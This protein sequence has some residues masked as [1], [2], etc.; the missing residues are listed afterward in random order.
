[1]K[2]IQCEKCGSVELTKTGNTFICQACGT[3]YDANDSDLKKVSIDHSEDIQRLFKAA[4]RAKDLGNY[5]GAQ[6]YYDEILG[7]NPDSWEAVFNTIYLRFMRGKIGEIDLHAT[8][9]IQAMPTII[10]LIHDEYSPEEQDAALTEVEENIEELNILFESGSEY[11]QKV[12][13]DGANLIMST[14]SITG[15]LSGAVERLDASSEFASSRS[16]SAKMLVAF[17]D[18]V[19]ETF[20]AEIEADGRDAIKETMLRALKGAAAIYDSIGDR[21]AESKVADSIRKWEPEYETSNEKRAREIEESAREKQKAAAQKKLERSEAV[22]KNKKSIIGGIIAV[23]ILVVAALAVYFLVVAPEAQRSKAYE[24][25]LTMT[26]YDAAARQLESLGDYKDSSE[27]AAEFGKLAEAESLFHSGH[28]YEALDILAE[29]PESDSR[30]SNIRTSCEYFIPE[31]IFDAENFVYLADS[32]RIAFLKEFGEVKSSG[33]DG[34][35]DYILHSSELLKKLPDSLRT[36]LTSDN[37]TIRVYDKDVIEEYGAEYST[38]SS[39]KFREYVQYQFDSGWMNDNLVSATK[40]LN[41]AA[42]FEVYSDSY[43]QCKSDERKGW[44]LGASS[45]YSEVAVDKSTGVAQILLQ[46]L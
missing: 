35:T 1:M 26:D 32:D 11:L 25:A 16:L 14:G 19:D 2:V 20:G 38:F 34:Y 15:L 6:G 10:G 13:K 40:E 8:Q 45:T 12:R 39:I 24:D 37:I 31:S 18:S 22:E 42:G 29:F 46:S 7:K 44:Y 21:T 17:A 3:S 9:M 33:G 41:E 43:F 30:A 4:R 36:H 27:R 28:V 5:E 23:I